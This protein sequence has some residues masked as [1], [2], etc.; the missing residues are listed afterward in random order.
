MSELK[1]KIAAVNKANKLANKMYPILAKV[2]E[3]LVG[4]KVLKSDGRTLLSKVEKLLPELP[5]ASNLH[6]YMHTSAYHLA[7]IVKGS[8]QIEGKYGCVYHEVVVYIGLL[9]GSTAVLQEMCKPMSLLR[10][11]YAL[12]EVEANRLLARQAKE[13]YEQARNA[14]FPFGE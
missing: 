14:C 6:V 2:F 8:E 9:Q 4:Q 7:W 13:A 12:E 5:D 11:D 1:A 10:T 3:P